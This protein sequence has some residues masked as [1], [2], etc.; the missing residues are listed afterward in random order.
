MWNNLN[1]DTNELIYETE[2]DSQRTDLRL[3]RVRWG[4]GR[5][6]WEFGVSRCKVLYTEWIN[7]KVQ[8]CS[9]GNSIQYPGINH[10]GKEY[11]KE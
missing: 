11:E 1:Y 6:G 9:T 4:G 7:N 2:T 5:M 8:L 3:P 10:N